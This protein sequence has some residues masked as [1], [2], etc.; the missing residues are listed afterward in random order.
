M[1][2]LNNHRDN[3]DVRLHNANLFDAVREDNAEYVRMSINYGATN[4]SECMV[5]ACSRGNVDV[6]RELLEFF[7][8]DKNDLLFIACHNGN[9]AL[10]ELLIAWGANDYRQ[11]CI[12]ATVGGHNDIVVY[13]NRIFLNE[14]N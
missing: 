3:H 13:L 9:Q 10:T 4:M 1:D 11:A 2:V 8:G 5:Y 7:D 6:V 12:W 14:K